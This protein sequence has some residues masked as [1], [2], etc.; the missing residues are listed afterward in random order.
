M[1]PFHPDLNS[2]SLHITNTSG[3]TD[4]FAAQVVGLSR[5]DIPTES[6]SAW[7]LDWRGHEGHKVRLN[8]NETARIDLAW[9]RLTSSRDISNANA[10][11]AS[12]DKGRVVLYVNGRRHLGVG[13]D[14]ISS[15]LFA[16]P[17]EGE[18]LRWYILLR[19]TSGLEDLAQVEC[20]NIRV[21]GGDDDSLDELTALLASERPVLRIQ[22]IPRPGD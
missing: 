15:A 2:A 11:M 22:P 18:I 4:D 3:R 16:E 1:T 6:Q 14:M 5:E 7:Y 13:D 10:S 19:F 17:G 20:F 9:M 21:T 8:A 12:S